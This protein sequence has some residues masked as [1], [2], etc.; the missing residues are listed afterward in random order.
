V[1]KGRTT[2]IADS[3]ASGLA[4]LPVGTRV[5]SEHEIAATF[6][7]SRAAARS[8]LQE[9]EKRLL[10]RRVRGSGTFVSHPIDFVI[11][12][13]R[14]PSW[15]QT[16][17]AAGA[18]PRRVVREIRRVPLP[19]ELAGRLER[20]AGSPA[21]LLVRQGYVND[22]LATWAHEWI[23][24]DVFPDAADVAIHAV[25]S[26]DLVLRQMAKVEPARAWCQVSMGL[27]PTAIAAGL[28]I[29]A[30]R[31]AWRIK[32]MSRDARG[33][34]PLMCSDSWLRAEIVRVSVEFGDL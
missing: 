13:R 30:G 24:D 29:A 7:V 2:D 25:E 16:V 31:Q 23:P 15:Q 22:L 6:D 11:S 20:P 14:P 27:P 3:L 1:S 26:L 32:S 9:L 5:A 34:Q 21:H 19:G 28:D 12:P 33:G 8:A 18:T 4:G 17:R 10:V